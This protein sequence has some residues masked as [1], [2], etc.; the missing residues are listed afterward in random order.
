MRAAFANLDGGSKTAASA[1]AVWD[2][3]GASK[4]VSADAAELLNQLCDLLD[5]ELNMAART[6]LG[7][8]T[9]SLIVA[10]ADEKLAST[11]QPAWD[12]SIPLALLRDA[13]TLESA[14]QL[15]FKVEPIDYI[16]GTTDDAVAAPTDATKRIVISAP[17]S[18]AVVVRLQ[19]YALDF[20]SMQP[21]KIYNRLEFADRLSA[22]LFAECAAAGPPRAGM[23]AM[24]QLQAVVAHD[25]TRGYSLAL[26]GQ[27]D[28]RFYRCFAT[29]PDSE[30]G[31]DLGPVMLSDNSFGGLD[32]LFGGEV[33]DETAYL[34]FFSRTPGG[35][36]A[37]IAQAVRKSIGRAVAS[38]SPASASPSSPVSSAPAVAAASAPKGGG[39]CCVLG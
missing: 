24:L 30:N 31:A 26:R 17:F 20:A 22:K 19:R 37:S 4:L 12:Y 34:L 23:D 32:V 7:V 5:A 38:S 1:Q 28:G 10:V 15:N 27:E 13:W 6:S 14:V 2:L 9:H 33:G 18:E 25:D 39:G 16:F 36:G 8:Q 21:G 11:G 29:D 3:I 35:G